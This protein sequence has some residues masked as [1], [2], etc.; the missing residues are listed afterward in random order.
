MNTL[1]AWLGRAAFLTAR[2]ALQVVLR[3]KHRVRVLV[4]TDQGEIL[5]V[6]SWFGRQQWSL[7]GGGTHHQEPARDACVREVREETG[8]RLD[9]ASLRQLGEF[10]H[11]DPA[12]PF[13]I[14]C[15]QAHAQKQPPRIPRRFRLEVLEAAWFPL[16]ELPASRSLTV[17]QALELLKK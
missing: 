6:R 4:S 9:P 16:K 2:P 7:P 8:V 1:Y 5:L 17:E 13:T 11:S 14:D 3:G 10:K 12:A 15:W